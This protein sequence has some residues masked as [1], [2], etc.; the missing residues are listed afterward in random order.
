MVVRRLREGG[1]LVSFCIYESVWLVLTVTVLLLRQKTLLVAYVLL[2]L[3]LACGINLYHWS[4]YVSLL[5]D[6]APERAREYRWAKWEG[7]L[8]VGWDRLKLL[9]AHWGPEHEEL[10]L[11]R[12]RTWWAMAT[13]ICL[14]FQTV[15]GA[16]ILAGI[17]N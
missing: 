2:G 6:A 5:Q 8:G 4:R 10:E 7:I 1:F 17:I 12:R 11:E 3:V 16:V 9:R 13:M 15:L 14:W